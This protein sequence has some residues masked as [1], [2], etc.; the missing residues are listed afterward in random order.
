VCKRIDIDQLDE[1][2]NAGEIGGGQDE[3]VGG[4]E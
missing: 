2:G 3:I 4:T 1:G